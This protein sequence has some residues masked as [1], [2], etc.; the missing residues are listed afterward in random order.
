VCYGECVLERD[1]LEWVGQM[2]CG[3]SMRSVRW[4][5][6]EKASWCACLAALFGQVVHGAAPHG[7]Q[8]NDDCIVTARR[9]ALLEV[10]YREDADDRASYI[11]TLHQMHSY[12]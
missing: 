1:G 3:G 6:G 11:R 12:V 7:P 2:A 4:R 5:S 8:P 9:G 10:L